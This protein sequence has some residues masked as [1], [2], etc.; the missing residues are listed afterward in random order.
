M[1]IEILPYTATLEPAVVAFNRRLRA[2]GSSYGWYEQAAESWLPER[3]GVPVWREHYLALEDGETVRGAYALK[4]QPWRIQ[5][6]TEVVTDWQGPV[7]E[8]VIS[9]RHAMLGIRLFRDM[10]KRRPLLYSWGH[11]GDDAPM[12]QLVR[13]LKWPTHPTP[14]CL[15]VCRPQ[16]FLHEATY[17]RRNPR[18]RRALDV[19][20]ATGTGWLALEA[21]FCALALRGRLAPA[22]RPGRP[23]SA[24]EAEPVETFGSWA[25]EVFADCVDAY[26]AIGMRDAVTLNALLPASGWPEA[27]RLRVR[28]RGRTLGWVAVMD[29]ALRDDARFGSMRVGSLIDCLAR[30]EDA[31]SIVAAATRFLEARG[32]DLI[33]SNQSQ[34][35]WIRGFAAAG[36][37]I[38]P[39]RRQFA[40]SPPLFEALAPFDTVSAGLHLTNLDGHGPH[41]L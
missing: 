32:V 8:G 28:R 3:P 25:D 17:L 12:L 36:Y 38:L 6:R 34:P 30:P 5:G 40:M 20:A 31:G 11:G 13:S 4:P 22:L 14:F 35:A 21:L 24:L 33:A 26:Q 10:L 29:H 1:A 2:S 27:I 9:E 19:L 15:K 7:S 41:G 39:G 37:L 18:V 23:A 16:P